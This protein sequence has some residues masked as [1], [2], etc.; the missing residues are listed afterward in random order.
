MIQLYTGDGKGKTSAAIG[1]AIRAK[2]CG[3]KVII[4]Q[5][6]KGGKSG[7]IEWLLTNSDIIIIRL[8]KQYGFSFELNAVEKA[9]MTTKH[10]NMLLSIIDSL[11]NIEGKY[12]IVLDEVAS[13][14]ECELV[15][16][17]LI[18]K[19][20]DIIDKRTDEIELIMTGRNFEKEII[21]RS[22]Y[23]S[24]I[25]KIKHPYDKGIMS[26]RGIEY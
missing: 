22:D 25:K 14:M 16:N 2:G 12:M 18:N 1:A 9:E 7:E 17:G 8:D 11:S 4:V 23:V 10:N 20:C 19:L 21:N 6:M 5:L 13:A 15:D 24:E 26:R 3:Y